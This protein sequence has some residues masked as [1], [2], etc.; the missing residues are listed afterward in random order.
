MTGL[1]C[2]E[3][4]AIIVCRYSNLILWLSYGALLKVSS[5]LGVNRLEILELLCQLW[6][7]RM[8]HLLVAPDILLLLE[9]CF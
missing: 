8:E 6:R 4:S 1:L 9:S 3:M 7:W 2:E 5:H